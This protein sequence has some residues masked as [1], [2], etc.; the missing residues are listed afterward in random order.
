MTEAQWLAATDPQ[1][2]LTFLQARGRASDRKLRLFAV[3][4]CRRIW[5]C[6]MD[7]RSCEAVEVSERYADGLARGEELAEAWGAARA[8][9]RV[10]DHH[11]AWAAAWVADAGDPS[12]RTSLES[13]KGAGPPGTAPWDVG[14]TT[15]FRDERAAQASLLRDLFGPL[16]FRLLPPLAPSLLDWNGGLVLHLA[17]SAYECR[18]EPGGH[19]DPARLAVLCDALLDAGLPPDAEILQHLRGPGPHWR[20]CWPLDLLLGRG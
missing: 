18:A 11:P 4:C 14:K 7:R 17:L 12:S 5:D 19:L 8:A 15:E 13:A 1:V 2:M 6:L 20:G 9:A 10:L 16:P 3:A